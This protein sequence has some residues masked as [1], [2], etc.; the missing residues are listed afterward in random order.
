MKVGRFI[1]Y[2]LVL[3]VFVFVGLIV[4]AQPQHDFQQVEMT[5]LRDSSQRAHECVEIFLTWEE[6]SNYKSTF[7]ATNETVEVIR[8]VRDNSNAKQLDSIISNNVNYSRMRTSLSDK[9]T[10]YYYRTDNLYYIIWSYKPEY[11]GRPMISPKEPFV[12]VNN[13]FSEV[14]YLGM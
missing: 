14:N 8:P 7:G 10:I 3:M 6:F 1:K 13:D 9:R 11:D 5:F 12:V 4:A 2:V